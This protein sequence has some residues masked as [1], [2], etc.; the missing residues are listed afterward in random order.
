MRTRWVHGES[1]GY[2][3]PLSLT[4]AEL[5]RIQAGVS[6]IVEADLLHDLGHP[7]GRL[8]ARHLASDD[9]RSAMMLPT[10]I[11]GDSEEK[12]SWN[13]ACTARR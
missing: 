2:R 6:H 9:E 8:P 11:R 3:D 13:T 4:T 12:G 5:M 1:S 7:I 10:R